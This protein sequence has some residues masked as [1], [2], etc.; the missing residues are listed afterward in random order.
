MTSADVNI[1]IPGFTSTSA[2]V[3]KKFTR[4][5]QSLESVNLLRIEVGLPNCRAIH[6]GFLL[7]CQKFF[8]SNLGN[9]Y[10]LAC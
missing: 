4:S 10:K 3:E 7:I 5:A 6:A 2:Y 9:Q 8:C 1:V